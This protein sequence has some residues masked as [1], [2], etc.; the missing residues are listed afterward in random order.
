MPIK[1]AYG[2]EHSTDNGKSIERYEEAVGLL[3]GFFNDPLETIDAALA[4][5]PDFVMG[6]CFKAGLLTTF[7]EKSVEADLM[8]SIAAA[9]ALAGRANERERAHM[10]AARAWAEGDFTRS[11]KLYGEIALTWPRDIFAVQISHIG[12]FYL[13]QSRWLRDRMAQVLPSWNESDP[14]YGYLLGMH[15]FGLEEMNEFARAE[16]SGRKAVEIFQG[17]AWAI[18]AVAHAMEMQGRADDGIA[19]METQAEN[20][21]PNNFFAF[22]NWWHTALY[23][24]EGGNHARVL[25]IYDTGVRAAPSEAGLELVDASALLWR[26]HLEGVDVDERWTEVVENWRGPSGDGYYA[27]NDFHATLGLV[28][29]GRDAEAEAI[30]AS[31]ETAAGGDGT[32]AM[33]ARKVGLP[34]SRAILAFGRGDYAE[35]VE[36]LADLRLVA[37]RF[38][39]SN[40]Q[41]DLIDWTLVEAA[42]RAGDGP[43]ARAFVNER[44]DRKPESPTVRVHAKRAAAI[45]TVS[46]IAAE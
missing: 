30:V 7:A 38:G 2:V 22:H 1:D 34:A 15:A 9:E 37:N 35:T 23:H 13:G 8:A 42:I 28:A 18:H 19:W 4:E 44:L 36:R 41:R 5:D 45:G 24:L 33:M 31:L 46:A 20:W 29:T 43:R 16:A 25:E 10:A 11:G 12:C 27:F 6:H 17:D 14:G 40:A 3:L 39:G 21:S 26:L 32:N